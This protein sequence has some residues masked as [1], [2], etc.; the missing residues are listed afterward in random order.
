[1]IP[2]TRRMRELCEKCARL[3]DP[4]HH[5]RGQEK[6]ERDDEILCRLR[7]VAAEDQKSET[8]DEAGEEATPSSRRNT[9]VRAAIRCGRDAGAFSRGEPA[10]NQFAAFEEIDHLFTPRRCRCCW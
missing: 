5:Q 10:A 7:L 6:E 2:K 1:M 9:P 4:E 8:G 3:I